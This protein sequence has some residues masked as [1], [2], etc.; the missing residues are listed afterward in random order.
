MFTLDANVA[1]PVMLMLLILMSLV[2][3]RFPD[4]SVTKI[5]L[6][7]PSTAGKVNVVI[8]ANAPGA[9]KVRK[10]EPLSVPSTKLIPLPV[11]PVSLVQYLCDPKNLLPSV[12]EFRPT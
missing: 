9:F 10:A 3:D 6:A 8:P 7:D 12:V 1:I 2:K 4:P 11:V 5:L